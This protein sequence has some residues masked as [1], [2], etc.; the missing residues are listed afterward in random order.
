MMMVVA[1]VIAPFFAVIIIATRRMGQSEVSDSMW[2]AESSA[3]GRLDA[4]VISLHVAMH[5]SY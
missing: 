2:L 1:V 5:V 4:C 3:G